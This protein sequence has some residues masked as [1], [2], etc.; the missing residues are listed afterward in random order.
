MATSSPETGP[1]LPQDGPPTDNT[2]QEQAPDDEDSDE[3]MDLLRTTA[4]VHAVQVTGTKLAAIDAIRKRRKLHLNGG[5]RNRCRG[6]LSAIR[7]ACVA[8][9]LKILPN[10]CDRWIKSVFGKPN[11]R[12]Q[13][14]RKKKKS[15]RVLAWKR[16]HQGNP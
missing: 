11:R 9:R 10:G 2:A 3:Q 6:C 7:Q 12:P 15:T 1:E 16:H 4:G 13:K 14:A 5:R 8:M